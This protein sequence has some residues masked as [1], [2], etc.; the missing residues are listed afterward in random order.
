MQWGAETKSMPYPS[1]PVSKRNSEKNTQNT[2][3]EYSELL[4]LSNKLGAPEI[5]FQ[6]KLTVQCKWRVSRKWAWHKQTWGAR[7]CL[8]LKHGH[9]AQRLAHF[10]KNIFCWGGSSYFSEQRATK[11]WPRKR[12]IKRLWG[13]VV[14]RTL[15]F[16]QGRKRFET[17]IWST[18]PLDCSSIFILL[19]PE[20]HLLS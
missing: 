3:S 19:L 9:L 18:F 2:L 17:E 20:A 11:D 4:S 7:I 10:V 1:L 16:D 12:K 13:K 5:E 6:S 15:G 8:P 14:K